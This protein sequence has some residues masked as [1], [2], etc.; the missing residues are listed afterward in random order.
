M[1]WRCYMFAHYGECNEQRNGAAI[2]ALSKFLQEMLRFLTHHKHLQLS[3]HHCQLLLIHPRRRPA[4]Q[5][6]DQL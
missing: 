6:S 2:L 1:M 4:H 3:Y 5:Q